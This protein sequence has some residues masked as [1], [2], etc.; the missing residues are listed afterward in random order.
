MVEGADAFFFEEMSGKGIVDFTYLLEE[1]KERDD[2]EK[3]L[4]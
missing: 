3:L 1:L 2:L 4:Q